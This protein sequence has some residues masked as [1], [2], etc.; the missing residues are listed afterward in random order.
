MGGLFKDLAN[1]FKKS[2]DKGLKD[3]LRRGLSNSINGFSNYLYYNDVDRLLRQQEDDTNDISHMIKNHDGTA[4]FAGN[5]LNVKDQGGDTPEIYNKDPLN[6]E[7]I[8]S[9]I[10]T[11]TSQNNKFIV[12]DFLEDK[13]LIFKFP[14]WTYADWIN[15]RS[16]WQR[17]ISSFMSERGW[18]YFK[19]FFDFRTEHGLLG[20]LLNNVND[21]YGG[22]NSALKFLWTAQDYY[23]H[24]NLRHRIVALKKF[25]SILSN[26]QNNTPWFFNSIKGLDKIPSPTKD[27]TKDKTFTINCSE[28]S[29][30]MRVSTMLDLY[31]Y[32]AFDDILNKEIIPE[33]LRKFDVTVLVF[34]TPIKKYHTSFQTKR[35]T[36]NYKGVINSTG[37]GGIYENMMT[38]KMYT[39]K[40]CEIDL[41]T[42]NSSQPSDL[43]NE[44]PINFKPAI[45]IK[46]DKLYIHN[47]NEF[48]GMLFGPDGIYYNKYTNNTHKDA[49]N[50]YNI[51]NISSV[52]SQ[53]E[54]YN[55]LKKALHNMWF[56]PSDNQYKELIDASEMLSHQLIHY[57][58]PKLE[59]K[60]SLAQSFLYKALQLGAYVNPYT[61]GRWGNIHNDGG[62]G[63]G[64]GTEYFREKLRLLKNGELNNSYSS[65][66]KEYK[67]K[68]QE[69]LLRSLKSKENDVKNFKDNVANLLEQTLGLGNGEHRNSKNYFWKYANRPAFVTMPHSHNLRNI[70]GKISEKQKE[71]VLGLSGDSDR[72]H[73]N[74]FWKYLNKPAFVT[75]PHSHSLRNK[76]GKISEERKEHM[77]KYYDDL[78]DNVFTYRKGLLGMFGFRKNL[79]GDFSPKKWSNKS[80]IVEK[81]QYKDS[82]L[83]KKHENASN[84]PY[85]PTIP[86][87]HMRY[88]PKNA[89]YPHSIIDYW[90]DTL[91]GNVNKVNRLEHQAPLTPTAPHKDKTNEYYNS[92]LNNVN[93][94]DLDDVGIKAIMPLTPIS[95]HNH[96]YND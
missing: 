81:Y 13:R 59:N 61:N 41:E 87:Q 93:T 82:N 16:M 17:G 66:V 90:K 18:F 53:E 19:I 51:N 91:V 79:L 49:I 40:N 10:K 34:N 96:K 62:T 43:N 68:Y 8:R 6:A 27:F 71:H 89:P 31:R 15:E 25:G 20:G 23:G 52:V 67:Y 38:Y 35:K 48:T 69:A 44:A 37:Y 12:N 22:V 45:Q 26:I 84:G 55:E 80:T 1:S 65:Y 33:N 95:P 4:N 2:V 70:F 64:P 47:S 88:L 56:N 14:D 73:T 36:F 29:V 92:L 94:L 11:L 63:F 54:R 58:Q 75:A 86:H 32:A 83:A 21:V 3:G 39:F 78:V 76:F 28:E 24:E 7:N 9:H 74:Y 57:T 46:Y 42:Y 50:L 85:S 5:T 77:E 30:D 60:K 72:N